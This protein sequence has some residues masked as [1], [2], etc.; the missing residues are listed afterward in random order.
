M[1][2]TSGTQVQVGLGIES[3]AAPNVAVAEAIFIPWTAYSMQGVAEK[4]MFKSARGIR[5]ESSD[6]M[7]RRKYSEG[8][9]S[10]V[11]NTAVV[12]YFLALAM[13][14]VSSASISDGTYTHTFTI[15][16]TNASVRTATLT[17]EQGAIETA[18]YTN[19]VCNSLNFDVSDEYASMTAELIGGF[20]STDTISESYTQETQFAYHQM[21]VKFGTSISNASGNSATPLKSF[22]LNINNNIQL[23]EAFLS[24]SNEIVS[25]GLI[26]GRL[27]I[28]G[29]YSLH[30]EN[31]TELAKYRANTLNAM[32][33]QF[34][35]PV[36]GGGSTT[37]KIV[38]NIG[39]V[40]LTK[41]PIEHNID[42]LLVLTQE[43]EVQYDATDVE[44]TAT[45]TN[46]V[47]NASS[48]VYNP[49]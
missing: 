23:D 35:G 36:V 44:L 28:T 27:S 20:P 49:A 32:I 5:N 24:G 4:A 3:L 22:Q 9:I 1:A 30:F 17:A 25:G 2:K 16:N 37:E 38:F 21:T 11:P 26:P 33:V 19:V 39:D 6:S 48:A 47:N 42:G 8:S 31:T 40:V 10:V 15:Q 13:G 45:V 46:L 7:I 12:P 29:S 34:T 43:F 14:S 18:Q 41:P